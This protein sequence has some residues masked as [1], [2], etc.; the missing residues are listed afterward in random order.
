MHV[1]KRDGQH[2][3]VKF[4]NITNRIQVLCGGLDSK[5]VDPAPIARKVVE[6]LYDGIST[7]ELDTLAAET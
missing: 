6:G 3:E 5:Y 4:D 2:Q 7:A 1:V